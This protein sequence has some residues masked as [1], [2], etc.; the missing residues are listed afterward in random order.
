MTQDLLSK[1]ARGA[2]GS[3]RGNK[4]RRE[5]EN[6]VK[7]HNYNNRSVVLTDA[8]ERGATSQAERVCPLAMC[9]AEAPPP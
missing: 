7:H 6:T 8:T 3:H 9:D 4:V 5:T 1:S 2:Q